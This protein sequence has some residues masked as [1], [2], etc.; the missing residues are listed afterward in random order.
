MRMPI[1]F[2]RRATLYD[3]TPNRP[4]H[5]STSASAAE[6]RVGIGEQPL[7]S[8]TA[9]DTLGLRGHVRHGSVE[10]TRRIASR[11]AFVIGTGIA[12]R[13]HDEL[14]RA[15]RK[16]LQR[17]VVPRGRRRGADVRVLRVADDADD[18]V[19]ACSVPA[20]CPSVCRPRS[21]SG[22]S[23]RAAVSLITATLGDVAVSRSVNPR[24]MTTGTASVSKNSGDTVITCRFCDFGCPGTYRRAAA[25]AAGQ[26]RHARQRDRLHAGDAPAARPASGEAPAGCARA[27]T[28]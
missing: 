6:Q 20:R 19:L 27:C 14:H 5:A 13:P 21:R 8:E 25:P 15:A 1:S 11:M 4:T 10:S 24:P 17:R 28:G 16:V 26:Q 2:V 18:L 23:S 3:I 9:L 22:N 7:L 12:R